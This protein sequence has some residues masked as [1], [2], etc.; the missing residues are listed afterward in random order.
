MV[1]L[2]GAGPGDPQLMTVRGLNALRQA[3]VVVYDHLVSERL[4]E[5]CPPAARRMY[6]G[7]EH[8]RHAMRQEAITRLLVREGRAG[9]AV[10]RLKG[11]DPLLFGRGGEEALALAKRACR[12]RS[13]PA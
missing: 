8:G 2:V 4:L 12:L 11:G 3:Q 6:V 10:V 9:R 7:K 1:W 5:E 13:S